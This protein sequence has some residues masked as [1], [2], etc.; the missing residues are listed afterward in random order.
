MHTYNGF[1]DV[2]NNGW[3][4]ADF[5][6]PGLTV[7]RVREVTLE[8]LDKG[9]LA[10][11]PTVIT[12]DPA[13]Y[14][15]NLRVIADAMKD[16]VAGPHILGIHLEGPFISTEPGAVGAH[17]KQFVQ[18]PDVNAFRQYQEWA[19]GAIRILTLAP[20]R[21]GADALIRYAASNGVVVSIGHHLASDTE[22]EAAVRA[23][24][25]LCTHVGNGCPNMIH[26][27]DNPLWWQLACDDLSGLFITDGHHLPADLIKVALRAKT[28]ARFIV[29]S[30]ASSLAG[31]PAGRY[32]IF[33]GLPVVVGD[34]GKIYSEQSQSLAGSHATMFECMNHLAGLNLLDEQGLYQVGFENPAR[35]L[36]ADPKA[37]AKLK[38]PAIRFQDGRFVLG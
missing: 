17:P 7:A 19:G 28:P 25:R 10:Y 22:L 13:V 24:A 35:L 29:T 14:R 23:G 1:I 21:P 2:Q 26:R 6:A 9:T 16:P 33:N 31:M 20:E 36:K 30:D 5:T 18:A 15:E 34:N 37:L 8:L 3:M 38:G 4:G 12:G 11:C 27:H 32:T